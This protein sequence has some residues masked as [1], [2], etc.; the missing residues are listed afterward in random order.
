MLI[1]EE[2]VDW[3][4]G[5]YGGKLVG[6]TP[7]INDDPDVRQAVSPCGKEM[8]ARWEMSLKSNPGFRAHSKGSVLHARLLRLDR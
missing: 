2:D 3:E 1:A 7:S 4:V 8:R 6:A 5:R